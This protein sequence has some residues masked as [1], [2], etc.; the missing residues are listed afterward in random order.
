MGKEKTYTIKGKKLVLRPLVIGQVRMLTQLFEELDIDENTTFPE[1]IDRLLVEKLSQA[2]EVIFPGQ[3]GDINWDLVE[4]ELLDEIISDF[5]SQN[6]R[7]IRR[8]KGLFGSL[9]QLAGTPILS[10][11]NTA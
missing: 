5:L 10:S 3:T 6:P 9:A 2:M 4:Y 7:L 11:K 1:L 8:L